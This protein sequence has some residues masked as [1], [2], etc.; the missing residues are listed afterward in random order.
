MT[1]ANTSVSSSGG[2]GSDVGGGGSAPDSG[3]TRNSLGFDLSA[4]GGGGGNAPSTSA[5]S[6]DTSRYSPDP[7]SLIYSTPFSQLHGGVP[8]TATAKADVNANPQ[9]G[10]G[11]V[12]NYSDIVK[13]GGSAEQRRLA[14]DECDYLQPNSSLTPATYLDLVDNYATPGKLS[15]PSISKNVSVSL[16]FLTVA[17][18]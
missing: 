7:S 5:S 17:S 6:L 11:T 16:D 13:P 8:Q 10:D 9:P 14:V 2:S 12:T 15:K 4:G 18:N 1:A 3:R